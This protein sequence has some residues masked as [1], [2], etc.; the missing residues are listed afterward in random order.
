MKFSACDL[1]PWCEIY[2]HAHGVGGRSHTQDSEKKAE[3]QEDA[4][5][6]S[7]KVGSLHNCTVEHR[8]SPG[9]PLPVTPSV[10]EISHYSDFLHHWLVLPILNSK[11]RHTAKAFGPCMLTEHRFIHSHCYKNSIIYSPIAEADQHFISVN[12]IPYT[13]LSLPY[14]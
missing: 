9:C 6:Y 12:T 4:A 11:Q 2:G 13:K 7:F 3:A 8:G 10:L 1:A 5:E 14:Y